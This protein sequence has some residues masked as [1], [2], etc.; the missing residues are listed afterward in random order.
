MTC[1]THCSC[2]PT[3]DDAAR[4]IESSTSQTLK[5]TQDQL[6]DKRRQLAK[7]TITSPTAG[8]VFP[9]ASRAE[10]TSEEKQLAGWSGWALD[11][12]NLGAALA[13]GTLLCQVGH[14]HRWE[15]VLVIDH[16]DIDLVATGSRVRLQLESRPGDPLLGE[17][18]ELS[19]DEMEYVPHSLTREHGG[20]VETAPDGRGGPRSSST[21][22]QGRVALDSNEFLQSGLRGKAKIRAGS[23]S[24]GSR[25]WRYLTH[26]FHFEL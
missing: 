6:A 21:V 11:K 1:Y 10:E 8:A 9:A 4:F 13:E 18:K 12:K 25:A 22:Y 24:L 20:D 16:K 26:T 5:T 7:L 3:A 15:A 19:S 23:R 14:P 2:A 17:L